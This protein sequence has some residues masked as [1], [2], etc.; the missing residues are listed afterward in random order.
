MD[1]LLGERRAASRYPHTSYERSRPTSADGTQLLAYSV[2]R[3]PI[4]MYWCV[5]AA[6][7][8]E[9]RQKPSGVSNSLVKKCV[10]RV[11]DGGMLWSV[12]SFSPVCVSF[13]HL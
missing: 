9:A 4:Y 11:V 1:V 10:R 12:L 6:S 2:I 13:S 5:L 3:T 8:V 7:E